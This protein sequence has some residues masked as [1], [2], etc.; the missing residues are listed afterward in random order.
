MLAA[1]GIEVRAN[2]LTV[3]SDAAGDSCRGSATGSD[4]SRT[5]VGIRA[6]IAFDIDGKTNELATRNLGEP[7]AGQEQERKW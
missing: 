3:W 2:D 6:G 4:S 1:Y 5:G 7:L